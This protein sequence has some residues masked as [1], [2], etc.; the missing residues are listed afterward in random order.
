[1][2]GTR[3][4]VRFKDGGVAASALLMGFLVLFAVARAGAAGRAQVVRVSRCGGQN[5]EVEQAVDGRYVYEVWMGCDHRIGFARSVDG[6]RTFGRSRAVPSPSSLSSF[7][8]SDPALAVASNGTL[9]V[10]FIIQSN[11]ETRNGFRPEITPAVAVSLDHGRSFARVSRLPVP[12][13][14]AGVPNW[15]D[16]DFLAA[17]RNGAVYVTWD[18][19]P[20]A[21]VRQNVSSHGLSGA[22]AAGEF[23]AVI[24]KSTDGGK[25][26]AKPTEISPDFPRGGVIAAPIVAEADGALD[27]LY[28]RHPTNKTLHLSPGGDYFTRST[29]SGKTWTTPVAVDPG[30]GRISVREWWIDASLAIDPRGNLYASWDTQHGSRDTAW[31]AWSTDHGRTW[32]A[33]MPVTSG[34]T[35]KLIEVAAAG[36][37]NV[38]VAWQTPVP[39]EGFATYLRRLAVGKGWTSPTKRISPAYGNAKIWPGDTFGLSTR[40]GSAIL[41]WGSASVGHTSE[42]YSTR[43]TLPAHP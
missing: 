26:W 16:R 33:P 25:T 17:G 35:E 3:R 2:F 23:N 41:S 38:Y 21:L 11:V 37:R 43:R 18:Y 36:L 20:N 29:N 32:S 10:S 5:G 27:V 28:V 9:Y 12:P 6:G 19:G 24:Q 30:A 39:A 22:A 1:M 15:G 42:I 14:P 40:N 8:P 34:S 4:Q 7:Y 13:G 31:L